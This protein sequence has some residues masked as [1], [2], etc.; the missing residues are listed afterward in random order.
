MASQAFMGKIG[1]VVL[2]DMNIVAGHAGHIRRAIADALLQHPHLVAVNVRRGGGT[3][4]RKINVLIQRITG[5]VRE[6]R[7]QRPAKSAMT[8]GAQIHLALSREARRVQD[9]G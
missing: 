7:L 5:T 9:A 8:P 2:G 1:R 6:R 4:G 3:E